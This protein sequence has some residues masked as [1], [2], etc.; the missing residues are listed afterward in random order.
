MD[1]FSETNVVSRMGECAMTSTTLE[2]PA[3]RR[4]GDGRQGNRNRYRYR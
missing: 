3:Q 4:Q 2:G 1:D